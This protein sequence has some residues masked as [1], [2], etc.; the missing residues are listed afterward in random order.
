MSL[1]PQPLRRLAS[2]GISAIPVESWNAIYRAVAPLVPA[3]ERWSLPGDKIHKGAAVLAMDSGKSLYRRLIT[4]WEPETLMPDVQEPARFGP[5]RSDG[6]S[7]LTEYMM[8]EDACHY[9]ADDILVKVDRAAMASSLETRV[10]LLDH[11]V[12]E[13]AWRLP[14][15]YKVRGDVGKHLLRQVLYRHV[16]QGLID[17]PKMGFGVPMDVWLRGPL[18]DWAASL[19]DPARLREDGYFNPKPIVCKWEE[20]QSGKCN[21][22]YHLWCIL[23]FQAWL[24]EQKKARF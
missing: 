13:F 8:L 10:P 14:M 5:P 22:Q 18:R 7:S 12:F 20:H 4:H 16:P 6:L 23:I 21:W 19:L 11:R 9:M 2:K 17:R 3:R 24:D 15:N 1:L